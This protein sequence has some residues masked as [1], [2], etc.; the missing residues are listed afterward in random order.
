MLEPVGC[1][2][3]SGMLLSGMVLWRGNVNTINPDTK[4]ISRL[5]KGNKWISGISGG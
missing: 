1:F 4:Q 5:L 2:C 3:F